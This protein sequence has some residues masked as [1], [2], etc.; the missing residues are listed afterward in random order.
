MYGRHVHML[1]ACACVTSFSVYD[2]ACIIVFVE[3]SVSFGL[4]NS[5]PVLFKKNIWDHAV[6]DSLARVGASGFVLSPKR[7]S[8]VG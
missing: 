4:G 3:L 8:G 6:F 2:F 7:K 5:R 1:K